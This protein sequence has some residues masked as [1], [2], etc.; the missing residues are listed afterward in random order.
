MSAGGAGREQAR[1]AHQETTSFRALV[2]LLRAIFLLPP[3]AELAF[4][5]KQWQ[6]RMSTTKYLFDVRLPVI[7]CIFACML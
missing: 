2:E 6:G 4:V 7:S 5:Q 3:G 1:E